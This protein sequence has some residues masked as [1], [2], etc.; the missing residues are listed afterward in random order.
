MWFW[1]YKWSYRERRNWIRLP[2]EKLSSIP[3][4]RP[5]WKDLEWSLFLLSEGWKSPRSSLLRTNWWLWHETPNACWLAHWL[6]KILMLPK[7]FPG[8]ESPSGGGWSLECTQES[9]NPPSAKSCFRIWS[10]QTTR[11][12]LTDHA[13]FSK[14]SV[15]SV[16]KSKPLC[17]VINAPP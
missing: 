3:L 17:W 12:A 9:G 16:A 4:G 7:R 10:R 11:V 2:E 14:A 1:K 8:Q 15:G 13:L 5:Y 6:N